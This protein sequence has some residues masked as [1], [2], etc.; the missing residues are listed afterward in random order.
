MNLRRREKIFRCVWVIL[1][2]L[3]R[4]TGVCYGVAP[5]E[6]V[7][8]AKAFLEKKEY[9]GAIRTLTTCVETYPDD[10]RCRGLR[11]TIFSLKGRFREA[12]LDFNRAIE[13]SPVDPGAY[14]GRG[15]VYLSLKEY[16][17]A[18]RDFTTV[19]SSGGRLLAV[20]YA[21]RGDAYLAT[22]QGNRAIADYT[23]AIEADPRNYVFHLSRAEL[24][25]AKGRRQDFLADCRKVYELNPRI[26]ADNFCSKTAAREGLLHLVVAEPTRMLSTFNKT[27]DAAPKKAIGYFL[28]GTYYLH[29]GL[30]K[31][32]AADLSK[33]AELGPGDYDILTAQ[34]D[35]FSS[36]EVYDKAVKAYEKAIE[37]KPGRIDAME[38]LSLCYRKK[39]DYQKALDI[40]SRVVLAEPENPFLLSDQA[41]LYLFTGREADSVRSF[42]QALAIVG[43]EIKNGNATADTYGSA[44]WAALFLSKFGDAEKFA[45]E[46]LSL[47]PLAYSVRAARGHALLFLGKKDEA[48]EEYRIFI[49]RGQNEAFVGN[50]EELKN[51]FTLLVKRY[52]EKRS[53][54]EW[55]QRQLWVQ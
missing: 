41:E 52:P 46:A 35:L 34:G 22:S 4:A 47:N 48:F 55:A 53:L 6:H 44:S 50:I 8:Q 13:L 32:A 38:N 33:A 17:N 21:M 14:L 9:D 54:L 45:G 19:I 40:I 25:H 36:Q 31:R 1:F 30:Y 3:L 42:E 2:I 7:A 43:R 23:G 29:A 27:I 37:L 39:R 28:R 12:L 11:G 15:A 5:E 51:S 26:E 10:A 24:Y 20:A 49:E 16:E 18:I